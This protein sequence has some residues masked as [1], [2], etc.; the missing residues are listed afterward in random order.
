MW[1]KNLTIQ[2][3]RVLKDV[4]LELSPQFNIIIGDN[5]S[6]KTSLLEALN[7][8]SKGRSFRTARIFEVISYL[9]DSILISA[10]VYSDSKSKTQIGISKTVKKT[11]IR[12]NKKDIHAQ[13]ELSRYLPIT[14][15]HP[16]SIKLITGSPSE[17]RAFIDWLCF[18]L[19]PSFYPIWKQYQ[20]ILKQRNSCLK[21]KKQKYAID[22]WTNELVK[23]QPQI[24]DFRLQSI[25]AL[26]P[27][28]KIISG[29]LLGK[30]QCT[31]TLQDGFPSYFNI[32]NDDLLLFYREKLST[33]LKLGRTQYGVHRSSL[34][35]LMNNNPA[36]QSAS[37]GQLKLICICLLLAQSNTISALNKNQAIILIDDIASEL[38]EVNKNILIDYLETLNQQLIISTPFDKKISLKN[39]KTFHVKHGVILEQKQ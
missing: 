11:K 15:V 12:I 19:H 28:L 14:V 25:E 35:I 16:D 31:I 20:H 7:I 3:C 4:Q 6:G 22:E 9:E 17:R 18:Y 26:K 13:S 10:S 39:S 1:V 34:N 27:F 30:L 32:K 33:D 21:N 5:G 23:L 37:R 2:N 36:I 24:H 29:K 38:D 8:L